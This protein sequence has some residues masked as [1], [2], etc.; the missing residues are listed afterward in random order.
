MLQRYDNVVIFS[1]KE[2]IKS[3]FPPDENT[4][5]EKKIFKWNGFGRGGGVGTIQSVPGVGKHN[6]C[7]INPLHGINCGNGAQG[8]WGGGFICSDWVTEQ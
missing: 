2:Q 7:Q 5:G 6:Q 4:M 8:V 3:I 1:V